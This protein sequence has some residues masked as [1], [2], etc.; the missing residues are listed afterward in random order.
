VQRW[1]KYLGTGTIWE[2]SVCVCVCVSP[3]ECIIAINVLQVLNVEL[4]SSVGL[5]DSRANKTTE[6]QGYLL[7][8]EIR[9]VVYPISIP[10]GSCFC[11]H[12]LEFFVS[13]SCL[14]LK[15][16]SLV[17]SISLHFLPCDCLPCP[18]LFPP[19]W[20]LAPPW[21]FPPVSRSPVFL[22]CLLLLLGQI[23][24]G[25]SRSQTVV[26]R[27][28]IK[29]S[30][31]DLNLVLCAAFGSMLCPHLYNIYA[32]AHQSAFASMRA[33]IF[34]ER[35]HVVS[36]NRW[37]KLISK[38]TT[39]IVSHRGEFIYSDKNLTDH[40]LDELKQKWMSSVK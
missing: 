32:V 30:F 13:C 23:V 20:L 2:L 38:A 22:V 34:D 19:V 12:D 7:Y 26:L 17:S 18:W 40:L 35:N 6:A 5:W 36:G 15:S 9:Q 33:A 1:K 24:C 3:P 39:Y 27:G 16:L 29:T 11:C 28:L 4:H 10:V 31:F 21:L 14:I 8:R 37:L 25:S